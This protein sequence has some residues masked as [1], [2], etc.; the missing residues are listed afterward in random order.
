MPKSE[1]KKPSAKKAPKQASGK[2][3]EKK[4]KKTGSR[5]EKKPEIPMERSAIVRGGAETGYV[6]AGNTV[7]IFSWNINGIR[8]VVKKGL[9]EWIEKESPDIFCLQETKA[10]RDQVASDPEASVLL[11]LPGYDSCWYSAEKKGYSGV[12]TFSRLGFDSVQ[13]GFSQDDPENNFNTE[14]RL[15]VTEIGNLQIWNAYFPNGGRG[16]ER[17]EYKIKFYKKCLELWEKE[18]KRG[19]TPVICGDFNTA[20]KEIDLARPQENS[21]TSGF[22]PEERAFIEK[23]ISS[24]YVDVFRDF[25]TEGGWYTY[26]DQVT[27]ARERNVGWRIDYFL[28]PE[29]KKHLVKNAFIQ[30]DVQGSDH[31]PV[32]LEILID[33]NL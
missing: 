24:G 6:P 7:R 5:A 32:G 10:Y 3:P 27:R 11:R 1:K 12:A 20:H 8:A 18:R 16:P 26:W 2:S 28:I 31:C 22:L 15:L 19:K 23:M 13:F 29:E 4:A 33:G 17:V 30:M 21:K 9:L 14:G 25:H